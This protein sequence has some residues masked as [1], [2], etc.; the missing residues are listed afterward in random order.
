MGYRAGYFNVD[1]D[2][3]V[4]IGHR[5]GDTATGSGNVFLGDQAGYS[6][7]GSNL[8][9]IDNSNTSNPLIWGDFA[10][11]ILSFM[12]T[13]GVGTKSP[14]FPMEMKKTGANASI[15]VDRTDG[16]TNYINA[17]DSFGNFGTVTDHPLRLVTNSQWRMRLASD[18]SLT[19][20][21]GAT[22][23]ADEAVET[24]EALAPVKYNYLTDQD[25]EYVGF[26]A[27]DVPELVAS[28][29]R[30]GMSAMDV[31]AVLTKVLQEQQTTVNQQSKILEELKS[32]NTKL[33]TRIIEL[34]KITK[35]DK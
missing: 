34:E 28:K 11:D 26:I 29:D 22:C 23:T 7:S 5:A 12:G 32:E 25:D 31:V 19:M 9:Y 30:K 17:T 16:A 18:N 33:M 21:N 24:L 13:I 15:V 20:K 4:Y 1:G 3:N 2:N 27:E 14:A 10:N 35:Q 6:E 8:L